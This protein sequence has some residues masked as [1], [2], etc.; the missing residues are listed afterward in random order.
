MLELD[1]VERQAQAAGRLNHRNIVSVYQFG[2]DQACAYIVMEFVDGHS[3]GEYLRRPERLTRDEVMCLMFQLLDALHY[4][5]EAGV[6]HRDI[7]PA[8]LMVDREGRLKVTDF[9][10]ARTE[11]SQVT[12]ANT[13]IGSP[14]Y[15]APEQYTGAAVDRRVDIFAAG[16]LLYK[17][18][19]GV[20]PFTGSDEAIM[21][22]IV[23]GQHGRL[24]LRGAD[25]SL[26]V[27]QLQ[28]AQERWY[29]N[30]G[31]YGGLADL[32]LSERSSAGH[33]RVAVTSAD[34]QGYVVQLV[35]SGAQARDASCRALQLSVAPGQT[36]RASGPDE[37]L[38]NDD[39]A[40]RRCW[41]L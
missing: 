22:Q 30:R 31:R 13:V 23:Y 19:S 26:A 18:L 37:R 12:R 1:H 14:G 36:T 11:S 15:M 21:Y 2:Q 8:N 33:Y 4:A 9:G 25:A 6:V 20:T 24:S 16:V 40:N 39:A 34:E 17:L 38:G 3:L 5:H 27:A 10:I 41:N 7:K 35:A 28:I 32:R 29:A